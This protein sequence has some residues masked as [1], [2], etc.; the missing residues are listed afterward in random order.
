MPAPDEPSSTAVFPG[1]RIAASSS[2]PRLS[3]DREDDDRHA[4]R[5]RLHLGDR[6]VDVLG[7]VGLGEQDHRLCAARPRER[8]VTLEPA[9]VQVARHRRDEEGEVGVR[10]HDLLGLTAVRRRA[11]HERG[12]PREDAVDH[13]RPVWLERDADPVAG[14]RERSLRRVAHK[15][16]R[17]GRGHLALLGDAG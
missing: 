5:D 7:D 4:D 8:E 3:I 15:P 14:D 2:S 11:P 9:Q 6:R 1:S 12:M 13:A 16:P 17:K 10:R